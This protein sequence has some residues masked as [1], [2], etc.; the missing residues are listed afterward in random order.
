MV[1]IHEKP[2][3]SHLMQVNVNKYHSEC[4]IKAFFVFFC[5]IETINVCDVDN[6]DKPAVFE[7]HF[8]SLNRRIN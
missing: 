2:I 8:L 4:D 3:K 1:S 5:C 7:Y 6:N